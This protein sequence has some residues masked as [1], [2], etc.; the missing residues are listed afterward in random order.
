[1]AAP[2]ASRTNAV[3]YGTMRENVLNLEVLLADGTIF[4]TG[5]GASAQTVYGEHGVRLGKRA[6]LREEV[7]PLTM[8]VMQGLIATLDPKTLM[9]PGKVL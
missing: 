8:E 2:S 9:N 4:H 5:Q 1:M 3:R 7:G 6:L